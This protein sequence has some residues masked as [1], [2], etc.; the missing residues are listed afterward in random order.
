M[1]VLALFTLIVLGYKFFRNSREKQHGR[2]SD[3]CR[4]EKHH[5]AMIEAPA[6]HAAGELHGQTG[7][8]RRCKGRGLAGE[9]DRV[10]GVLAEELGRDNGRGIRLAGEG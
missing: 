3:D 1:E 5:G 10:A 4:N 2:Y 6:Q 9:V 8:R 7:L